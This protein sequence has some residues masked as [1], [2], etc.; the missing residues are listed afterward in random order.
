MRTKLFLG[1]FVASGF[2]AAYIALILTVQGQHVEA[3]SKRESSETKVANLQVSDLEK[4][5][6]TAERLGDY[7][8]AESKFRQ[9]IAINPR[10]TVT[11]LWL[12]KMYDKSG[13]TN[14]AL[15]SY[16]LALNVPGLM[17]SDPAAMIRFGELSSGVGD[18][19]MA[20]HA[21]TNAVESSSAFFGT[22][23]KPRIDE[24]TETA[25]MRGIAYASLACSGGYIKDQLAAAR[26]AYS[27]APDSAYVCYAYGSELHRLR[28]Y[29]DARLLFDR[30]I[31]LTSTKDRPEVNAMVKALGNTEAFAE[32]RTTAPDGK[33]TTRRVSKKL[34]N[35]PLVIPVPRKPAAIGLHPLP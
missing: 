20:R 5:A 14:D 26:K 13:R 3:Q 17:I 7:A 12:A 15:A 1:L 25:T 33:T 11:H 10:M 34:E 16:R 8:T 2:S 19:E 29:A 30:A 9:I 18:D 27:L 31:S 6:K 21:F 32:I 28:Q 4:E 35:L 23:L 22:A 24:E